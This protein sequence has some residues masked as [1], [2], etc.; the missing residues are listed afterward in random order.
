MGTK[1]WPDSPLA[2]RD[3]YTGPVN[4][5]GVAWYEATADQK[6]RGFQFIRERYRLDDIR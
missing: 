1:P 4:A 5:D 2:G 6:I 3:V